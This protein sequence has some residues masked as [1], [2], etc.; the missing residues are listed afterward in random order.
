MEGKHVVLNTPTGSG[1]SLVAAALHFKGLAEGKTSFYTSPIKA[2]VNEKFFDLCRLFGPERVGMLTGDASINRD[3]PII[4]CTAE[5]LANMALRDG[6]GRADYVVMDEFHYYADRERGDG[7]AD[8]AAL[9][10]ADDVPLDVGHARRPARHHRGAHG[11]DQARG[12]GGARARAPGAAGVRL[13]RDA[14]ARDDRRPGHARPGAHL[15]GQLHPAGR[16]RGGAEPDERRRLIEGATRRPC[17]TRSRDATFDTPYGKEFQ[18]FLR[19]GIGIHH[20]GLLPRYRLLVEQLAQQGLL[21]GRQRHRHAGRRR[22][23]PASARC[24]SRS[25]ASST[26]RR[27]ASSACATSSRSPAAPAARASTSVASWWRRRRQHVIENRRLAAKQARRQ[28]GGDA[29]AAAPR[30][31]STG[32]GGRSTGW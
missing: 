6:A 22:E 13:P 14:A 1:K 3:A 32:T 28:E 15:P 16:R 12:G 19:H 31:T 23:R 9:P 2:L 29:E 21:E 18:R 25:S 11:A 30:A 7:L 24:C 26:A 5:I 10:A 20:A 17:A 4:C 8:P 27:P